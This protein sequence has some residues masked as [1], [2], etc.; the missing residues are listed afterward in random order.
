M[1][2]GSRR[3]SRTASDFP[4]WSVRKQSPTSAVGYE[5]GEQRELLPAHKVQQSGRR[6]VDEAQANHES[7]RTTGLYDRRKDQMSVD[8]VERILI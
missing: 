5:S 2:L 6:I 7:A 4:S 3:P 1:W 8:E